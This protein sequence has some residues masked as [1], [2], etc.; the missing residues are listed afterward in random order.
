MLTLPMLTIDAGFVPWTLFLL[1]LTAAGVGWR[2]WLQREHRMVSEVERLAEKRADKLTQ[3]LGV[4]NT[5]NAT[6]EPDRLL[7]EIAHAVRE[8][9]G[10]RMVLV[11]LLDEETG[12]FHARAFAGLSDAD[13]EKLKENEIPLQE[14]RRLMRDEFLVGRCYFISHEAQY[15][16]HDD[17]RLVIPD[18]GE[19]REGEWHPL[20]SLFVPLETRDH[21][22]IGY[23]S[24]DDPVD[25]QVPTR[26]TIEMLEIFSTQAVIAIE[27]AEL[28]SDL[29]TKIEELRWMTAKLEESNEIRNAFMAN[30]SHELRTPLTS[31]R[32]YLDTVISEVRPKLEGQHGHFLNVILE[33]TIRLTGLVDD[34]LNFSR[35][36]AG[37]I[38][39][40]REPVRIEDLLKDVISVISP[41]ASRKGL[42][43]VQSPG[44]TPAVPLD[45]E[46]ITQLLMNLLGNAVKFTDYGGV[47]TARVCDETDGVRVEVRDTG[48]GISE[49]NLER[50]FDRFYQTDGSSTR[51]Y[52]GVGLGLAICRNIT[53][54]HG[55]RI[56]VESEVGKGS[57]F[58]AW[59]PKQAVP[60][61]ERVTSG[62]TRRVPDLIVQLFA[63]VMQSKSASIMLVD[64]EKRELFVDSAT[65]LDPVIIRNARV[66]VGEDI[67]GWVAECGRPVLICNIEE[68]DRFGRRNRPS[69]ESKSLLSVPLSLEN[70]VIGVLNVTNR[71]SCTA[72]TQDDA[73]LLAALAN[74]LARVLD[75]VAQGEDPAGVLPSTQTALRA[76]IDTRRW[77]GDGNGDGLSDLF[78][79]VCRRSGMDEAESETMRYISEIYDVGMSRVDRSILAKSG[80]LEPGDL[81]QIRNHPRAGVDLISPL[82]FVDQVRETVLHH[83]ERY[84]GR[85]YPEGLT[86]NDIP[87]G[88]RVLA[89]VDAFRSMTT[90]RSYRRTRTP[91][92]ALEE[93]RRCA[94]TQF[95]PEIVRVF[96][97]EWRESAGNVGRAAAYEVAPVIAAVPAELSRK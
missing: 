35:M 77:K 57:V 12:T 91:D 88:A 38:D 25:R 94:G 78:A 96:I 13:I 54:R 71:V 8:S 19:R 89:V 42:A 27:N 4:A 69:Y 84:D 55:G 76:I 64:E 9:L 14:F 70:R 85:G 59:F 63:E 15:W 21:R 43:V 90:E 34:L 29:E 23:L 44:S 40:E 50:V 67:S 24:V 22:L 16:D 61:E 58:S 39:L 80:R 3:I 92:E 1:A 11:R 20:D 48:I 97:E 79:A 7:T 45:R 10:F 5:M 17:E 49:E 31:I 68:D 65:G 51:K 74:R 86:G 26:E 53:E 83:H 46:L 37:K 18:L 33:E 36:E 56:W 52:G 41:E 82:E 28:Y 66:R 2:M 62:R 32:A 95:D 93:I 6:L 30:V 81:E 75:R 72:F 87:L 60:E 73:R 47:V